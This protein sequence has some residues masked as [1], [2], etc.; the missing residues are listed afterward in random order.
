MSRLL[1]SLILAAS[2]TFLPAVRATAPDELSSA[3][4]VVD[5][6]SGLIDG[7]QAA[8]SVSGIAT[9]Y[10]ANRWVTKPYPHHMRTAYT[11]AGIVY[12]VAAG[13][14]LRTFLGWKHWDDHF[15][16]LVTSELTGVQVVA[17]VVD[18]CSCGGRQGVD[19][20]RLADLS[21]A[22]FVAL[23]AHLSRGIQPITIE[24]LP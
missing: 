9:W 10:D 13:P 2:L 19:D 16:V 20:N 18:W 5:T 15:T 14:A 1:T 7:D 24:V 3:H 11:D 23:G 21:P 6:D 8:P 22:L 17:E 4:F 12:Y